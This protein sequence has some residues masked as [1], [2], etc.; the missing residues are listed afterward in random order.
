[1][2]KLLTLSQEED[3]LSLKNRHVGI[4][5]VHVDKEHVRSICDMAY[6]LL[7]TMLPDKVESVGGCVTV[8]R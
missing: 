4:I 8:I 6:G 1:M 5:D 3:G 2:C 7:V